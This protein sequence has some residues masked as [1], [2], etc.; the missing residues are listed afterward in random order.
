VVTGVDYLVQ[1]RRLVA[2][3][4][5]TAAS[6]AARRPARDGSH[7]GGARSAGPGKE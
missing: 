7:P 4:A 3:S 2:T 1:A 5:R 6:R